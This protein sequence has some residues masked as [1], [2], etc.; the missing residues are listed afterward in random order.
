MRGDLT[1]MCSHADYMSPEFC[2]DMRSWA[3]HMFPDFCEDVTYMVLGI[4]GILVELTDYE[5][6]YAEVESI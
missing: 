1:D 2:E 3:D 5:W 4:D 6:G